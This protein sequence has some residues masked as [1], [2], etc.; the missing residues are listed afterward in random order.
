MKYMRQTKLSI[1]IPV[2]NEENTIGK[3]IEK[4]IKI[5]FPQKII[6]EI[7]VVDDGSTDK[8]SQI[9]SKYKDQRT[10][11]RRQ[12]NL[13]VL[14]H[15]KNLGKGAAINSGLKKVSGDI[16]VIQDADLEYNP[17][18]IK[19]LIQPLITG[20]YLVVYGSRFI[21]F[22]LVL[23]GK[24]KT[25]LIPHYIANILLSFLTS[26]LFGQKI[27]DMET[28]Y[29]FFD[30]KLLKNLNLKSNRFNFEPEVTAKIL[31]RGI[32]ILE[33]PIKTNPRNYKE[34][35]KITWKDGVIALVTLIKYK[36]TD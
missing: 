13:S 21:D 19:T 1:I 36:L 5:K 12:I 20:K 26:F 16:V 11:R 6:K 35:K 28:G 17:E 18:Y 25:P 23:S 27:T 9:L 34:G 10:Y 22:L 29:K 33:L 31:K 4:V 24:N 2:F 8:T 15:S 3:I 32:R 30:A 7:I 14:K